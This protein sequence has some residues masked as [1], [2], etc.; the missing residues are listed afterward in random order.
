MAFVIHESPVKIAPFK[1]AVFGPPKVGKSTF[2]SKAPKPV[3]FNVDN[4]LAGVRDRDGRPVDQA[5]IRCA[6]DIDDGL[7][8]LKTQDHGYKTLVIDSVTYWDYLMRTDVL[9]E[10]RARLRKLRK[11]TEAEALRSVGDIPY[12]K[13]TEKMRDRFAPYTCMLSDLMESRNMN[14]ILIFHGKVSKDKT[15]SA[16]ENFYSFSVNPEVSEHFRNWCDAILYACME[17]VKTDKGVFETGRRVLRCNGNEQFTAGNIYNLPD[18]IDNDFD[19][20]KGYLNKFWKIDER[21]EE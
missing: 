10:E 14:V 5:R 16:V 4:Q 8:Y 11:V 13:G 19:V 12:G 15:P 6:K 20:F 9:E 21:N 17:T 2:A 3:F 7:E 1:I 18:E